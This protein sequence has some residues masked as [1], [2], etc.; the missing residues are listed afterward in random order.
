ME[1]RSHPAHSDYQ[2]TLGRGLQANE[3]RR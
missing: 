2:T 1:L 3:G